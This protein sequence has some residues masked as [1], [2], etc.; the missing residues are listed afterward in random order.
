MSQ[1]ASGIP[2]IDKVLGGGLLRAR[3]YLIRGGPGSGKTTLGLH[4][5]AAGAEPA[6]FVSMGERGSQLLQDA[7]Q[8]DF[9][10]EHL[11]LL[12][13]S[14]TGDDLDNAEPYD[15]FTAAE[16]EQ[17][18]M[19][20][21]IV[22][23]VDELQPTRVFI[24]S[25]TQLRYLA[26]S[27]FQFRKQVLAL[28]RH[29]T[30]RGI[31]VLFSAEHGAEAPDDDLRFLSDGILQLEADAAG[32]R[33]RVT[34]FRGNQF[35]EGAHELRLAPEGVIV[36]PRLM[37]EARQRD[38]AEETIACGIDRLDMLLNGGLERGTVSIVS[39]PTGVGKTTLGLQFMHNA[40][41]RG[42]RSVVYS[43]EEKLRTLRTRCE[44]IGVPLQRMID[45]GNLAV[46]EIEA[47]R[48]GPDEFAE[49]VRREVEENGSSIVMIDSMAGYRLSVGGDDMVNRLHALCRYLIGR[50]V[51]VLV[52]NEL[53]TIAGGELR[54]TEQ[55]FSY[56]ADAV[57]LMRYFELAG[58]LRKCI[59]VLKK[60]TSDF[61]KT[62]REFEI[63]ADGLRVGEP[64]RQMRGVLRGDP[65]LL[66][67]DARP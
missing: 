24:D 1:I 4:F 31:T 38:F 43:F 59:G 11:T 22:N 41:E 19:I 2:G 36:Y 33:F 37:P 14:P 67:T 5:L 16:V 7:E 26:N 34:K 17:Q 57:L 66:P 46:H 56:L 64:L 55:G 28:L 65:D 20:D 23:A 52:M 21:R 49:H 12:D 6:L 15:L 3:T 30:D 62:L 45:D 18:P 9:N 50:G 42:E 54:A 35:Q 29:L 8:R 25:L 63:T 60:R 53:Q 61:E 58:E 27:A 40:A 10:T 32:R 47:L 51:T 39:G 44:G 13:L 48:Y